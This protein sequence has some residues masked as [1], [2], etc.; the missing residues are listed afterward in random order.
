[1]AY[2]R[3]SE[4]INQCL[5]K[6]GCVVIP[7]LG[8]FITEVIPARYDKNENRAYPPSEELHFNAALSHRDGL[9]E[10]AYANT[11]GVSQRRARIMLDDDIKSL[12]SDL[13][14]NKKVVLPHIGELHLSNTGE[15]SFEY[16]QA[17]KRLHLAS[18]GLLPTSMPRLVLQPERDTTQTETKPLNNKYYYIPIHKK[19][20]LTSAAV[21]AFGALFLLPFGST[22][23]QDNC[24]A[25][26]IPTKYVANSLWKN[27]KSATDL[28]V[29]AVDVQQKKSEQQT[30]P[31]TNVTA[32]ADEMISNIPC[33]QLPIKRNGY[34]VIIG[35]FKTR[36]QVED[37]IHYEKLDNRKDVGI[38]KDSYWYRIY[39]GEY[40]NSKEA[41]T[42]AAKIS[43]EAWVFKSK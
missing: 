37:F 33:Y 6:T 10:T 20:L 8:G 2:Q 13:V 23:S 25:A 11:Y 24:E 40:T 16:L 1:M 43:N 36:K 21:L 28:P 7:D 19:T 14:A 9:L 38:L 30:A 26:F 22:N 31:A 17:A 12:R 29:E 18:Y 3:L 32:S 27:D 5:A 15:L 35:S 42:N 39:Q 4:H 41:Y 34:F